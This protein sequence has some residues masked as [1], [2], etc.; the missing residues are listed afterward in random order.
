MKNT[1]LRAI[2]ETRGHSGKNTHALGGFLTATL[3]AVCLCI[4]TSLANAAQ[5]DMNIVA[6][7]DDDI[8]FMNP[9]IA[10]AI[11]G[12]HSILTVFLTAGD[13]GIGPAYMV[14]RE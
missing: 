9:D 8:L 13:A 4:G 2:Q 3:L 10:H 14:T 11:Q 12:N 6:H 7:Q 5:R 1:K